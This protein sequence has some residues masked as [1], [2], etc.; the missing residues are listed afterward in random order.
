M[1][2]RTDLGF[3]F[4]PPA[5]N[6]PIGHPKLEINLFVEPT[7]LHFDPSEVELFVAA[8]SAIDLAKITHPWYGSNQAQVVAGRV[9]I[10]DRLEEKVEAFCFGGSIQIIEQATMTTCIITSP[11]PIFDLN[12]YNRHQCDLID[13]VET[14]FALRRGFWSAAPDEFEKRLCQIEPLKLYLL[15]LKEIERRFDQLPYQT[16]NNR[17]HELLNCI[18]HHQNILQKN[19]LAPTI[20]LK[21]DDLL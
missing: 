11:A 14:I 2:F 17:I 6:F 10:S 19:H 12:P 1:A 21:I 7:H 8:D 3:F 18:Q 5:E 13:E 4:H 20:P 15:I 9:I 16:A